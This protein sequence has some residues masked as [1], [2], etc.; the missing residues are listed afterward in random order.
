[1]VKIQDCAEEMPEIF[2]FQGQFENIEQFD[3]SFDPKTMRMT[4]KDFY[5]EGRKVKKEFT[6][7]QND[8]ESKILKYCGSVKE[9]IL[10]DKPA[11]YI[12]RKR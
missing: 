2:E 8:K 10:F 6:I 1:M 3:G 12:V 9:V 11:K 5:L 4:F 7:I